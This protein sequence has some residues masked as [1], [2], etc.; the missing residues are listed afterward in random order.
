MAQW[1]AAKKIKGNKL[2]PLLVYW[3]LRKGCWGIGEDLFSKMT[4]TFSFILLTDHRL[5]LTFTVAS[6]KSGKTNA[7]VRSTIL[8][9]RPTI[10][11]RTWKAF[12]ADC[13]NMSCSRRSE[14]VKLKW[15]LQWQCLE[16][17]INWLWASTYYQTYK[18]VL[19]RW[20]DAKQFKFEGYFGQ[21][22]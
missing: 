20:R 11:T 12:A 13:E 16:S 6:F 2:Q 22:M 5:T 7:L 18:D 9:A 17:E 10:P 3:P 15:R 14:W 19:V 4:L 21:C 1:S 8:F